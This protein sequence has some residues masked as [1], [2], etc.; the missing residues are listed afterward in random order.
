[1]TAPACG[2]AAGSM[3]AALVSHMLHDL[4]AEEGIGLLRRA[5]SA[6]KAGFTNLTVWDE[7]GQEHSIDVLVQNGQLHIRQFRDHV[8][9]RAGNRTEPID[10]L[11]WV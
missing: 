1:M 4:S 9:K 8:M 5:I 11:G 3:D 2:A 7:K 10:V 6:I